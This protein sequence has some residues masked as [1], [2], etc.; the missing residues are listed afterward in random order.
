MDANGPTHTCIYG[1]AAHPCFNGVPT[2]SSLLGHAHGESCL[3]YRHGA[4][5][6]DWLRR[7]ALLLHWIGRG[8]N[9][10]SY[11]VDASLCVSYTVFAKCILR[12]SLSFSLT[13]CFDDF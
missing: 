9:C 12:W 7:A 11:L 4:N 1:T 3:L 6:L 5:P 2:L 10:I 13:L 8:S